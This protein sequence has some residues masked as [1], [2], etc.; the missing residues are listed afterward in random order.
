MSGDLDAERNVLGAVLVAPD[1]FLDVAALLRPDDFYRPAHET[2]WRAV[3]AQSAS[4]E[5]IDPALLMERLRADGD[6]ARSGG[7]EYIHTLVAELPSAA[8]A[9]YYARIV[10]AYGA[11]RRVMSAATTIEQ[12]AQQST[13]ADVDDLRQQAQSMI[14]T[15][16]DEHTPSGGWVYETLPTS[17][18]M[19]TEKP[20]LTPSP[21]TELDRHIGG[22]GAGRLYVIG[23]RPG[24][25]KTVI[26]LQAAVHTAMLGDGA[27]FV[28]LEMAEHELHMRMLSQ[29]AKVPHDR[30]ERRALTNRDWDQISSATGRAAS[31]PVNILDSGS[32]RPHDV[33]HYVRSL[34]RRHTIA[35]TVVD[36]LQL[37]QSPPGGKQQQRHE[38]VADFSRQLKLMARERSTA[39]IA[40]SQLNRASTGRRDGRPSLADLRETGA[41]EQDADAVILLH[42]DVDG[43]A[44]ED[45][46]FIIA[47]NRH[48]PT[49]TVRVKFS[50]QFQS[51]EQVAWS[52]HDVLE[53]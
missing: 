8:N 37:M 35:V 38:V 32:V 50:G 14:D 11:I 44:P 30:L 12:I 24:V 16:T 36:Y 34:Q 48:G 29:L 9:P 40:C 52:P 17:L 28:S 51:V 23:A 4:D 27:A 21:W 45:M 42:R 47:K 19:L 2:I 6:L 26:A 1:A 10:H 13:S 39:V 43:D 3:M 46:E 7:A 25:G 18:D 20:R 49:G 31:L 41:I 53:R 22:L 15:A 5:P 33:W